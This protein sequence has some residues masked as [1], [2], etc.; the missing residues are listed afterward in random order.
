MDK[1]LGCIYG[2]MVGDALGARYE[3]Q[4][5]DQV[6][7]NIR[8]DTVDGFL[9]ILGGGAFRVAPGQVTDDSEMMLSLLRSLAEKRG[10]H[11][12]DVARN[13]ITWYHS[14]PPDI[15]NTTRQA[16]DKSRSS[17]DMVQKAHVNH[18]SLSNGAL[19]RIAPLGVWGAKFSD[20]QLWQIVKLECNLTHSNP[21]VIDFCFLYVLAIKYSILG[22]SKEDIYQHL[23]R[24]AST[25]RVGKTLETARVKPEPIYVYSPEHG[26]KFVNTDEAATGYIGTAF[27]NAIYEFMNGTNYGDSIIRIIQRGADTD[28]NAAIAGGLLGAYYGIR[29]IDQRWV[30]TVNTCECDRYMKHPMFHPRYAPS[31]VHVLL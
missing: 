2:V 28:T 30:H 19:M 11:Q 5:R 13:Y 26:E 29:A 17:Q 12:E 14:H 9:P 31:Y 24:M 15:G 8:R 27:Q 23:Q 20:E 21:I 3:F 1:Y 22:F 4:K 18:S 10:Y 16:L 25:P 6:M 7:E